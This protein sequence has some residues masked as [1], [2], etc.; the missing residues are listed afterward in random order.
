MA[1]PFGIDDDDLEVRVPLIRERLQG[2][3][4]LG[5]LFAATIDHRADHQ[6]YALP[7]SKEIGPIG[8]LVH[9]GV[10]RQQHGGTQFAGAGF[11]LLH[12]YG[13]AIR[14]KLHVVL[15]A[16]RRQHLAQG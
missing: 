4:V 14:G 8:G 2:L 16:H 6:R 13:V 7:S 11:D 1:G 9:D 5:T 3:R 15:D 12:A 10:H